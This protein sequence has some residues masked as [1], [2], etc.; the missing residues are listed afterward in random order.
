MVKEK[1]II[2]KFIIIM[3]YKNCSDLKEEEHYLNVGKY[4]LTNSL[5]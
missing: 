4:L 5:A 3:M 2:K 1:N